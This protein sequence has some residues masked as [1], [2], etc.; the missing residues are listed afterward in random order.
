MKPHMI[1]LIVFIAA[2]V[3]LS[4]K[5]ETIAETTIQYQLSSLQMS[6]GC[7]GDIEF[8]PTLIYPLEVC[9][10]D[11]ENDY[12]CKVYAVGEIGNTDIIETE[13]FTMDTGKSYRLK[14]TWERVRDPY[15]RYDH[16]GTADSI[17]YDACESFPTATHGCGGQCG[18]WACNDYYYF[19]SPDCDYATATWPQV[20]GHML[21]F[22]SGCQSQFNVQVGVHT[23]PTPITYKPTQSLVRTVEGCTL[24]GGSDAVVT[25]NP[26]S[27]FK[28]I[29]TTGCG[30]EAVSYSYASTCVEGEPDSCG[31]NICTYPFGT[32][33]SEYIQTDGF[34]GIDDK[35]QMSGTVIG[36]TQEETYGNFLLSAEYYKIG[37]YS[38]DYF[39]EQANRWIT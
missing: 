34:L 22:D 39:I 19:L 10:N 29:P 3:L 28:D 25:C 7:S 27:S 15:G 35:V 18:G 31:D 33:Y 17:H 8:A 2:I 16:G 36:I 20:T 32:A 30:C 21:Y 14:I 6:D 11:G 4:A 24:S 13:Q 5:K 38:F 26:I 23:P 37:T 9:A 1:L 12:G